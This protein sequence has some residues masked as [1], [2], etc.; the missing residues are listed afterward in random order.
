MS[1]ILSILIWALFT[2]CLMTYASHLEER[3]RALQI[4]CGL[5]HYDAVTGSFV[6]TAK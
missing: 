6:E 1:D 3:Y 4:R 5:G 2:V